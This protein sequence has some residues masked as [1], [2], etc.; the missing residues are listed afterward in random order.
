MNTTVTTGMTRKISISRGGVVSEDGHPDD[1]PHLT[2]EERARQDYYDRKTER[3]EEILMPFA[4]VS[5]SIVFGGLVLWVLYEIIRL[6][7]AS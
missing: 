1:Y 3:R 4:V 5:V 2:D 6:W 7:I